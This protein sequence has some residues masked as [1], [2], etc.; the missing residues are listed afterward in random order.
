YTEKL[1]IAGENVIQSDSQ[2]YQALGSYL[3]KISLNASKPFPDN[4][5]PSGATGQIPSKAFASIYGRQAIITGLNEWAGIS[6]A[7]NFKAIARNALVLSAQQQLLTVAQKYY[8]VCQL[9][10]TLDT[11]REIVDLYRKMRIELVRRVTVGKNR[12]SDVLRTDTQISRLEAQVTSISSQLDTAVS[13]LAA[14]IGITPKMTVSGAID[15]P[16]PSYKPDDVRMVVSRRSEVI[17]A[18]QNIDVADMN[19][20][21]AWGGHLPTVYIEGN[22]RLYNENKIPG[23]KFYTAITASIPI[24]EGG[25]TTAKVSEA[26]SVKRQADLTLSQTLR[27]VEEDVNTSYDIWRSSVSQAEAFKNALASAERTY[28]VTANDYRLNLVT[29][30]DVITAL[31]DLQQARNDYKTANLIL[32]F[33]RIRLGVATNEFPGNGN[34]TLKNAPLTQMGK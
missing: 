20:K 12:Q 26:Q 22:Y 25:I 4:N 30:I 23:D 24:F 2:Y 3:P 17:I 10:S 6:L 16:S 13:D 5:P 31:T 33:D 34:S 27:T 9:Q 7:K 8:L 18:K 21:A 14:T 28:V 19:L 29:I 11:D 15:L 1:A 32:G